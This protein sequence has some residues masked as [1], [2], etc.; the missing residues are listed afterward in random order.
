MTATFFPRRLFALLVI[1]ASAASAVLT[2]TPAM[3][4]GSH[5]PAR[6]VSVLTYN[7]HHGVGVDGVLDLERIATVIEDSGADVIGL[8]EV[9]RHWSSRSDNVDQAA[10]LAQRLHLH[11][12]FAANLDLDPVNP[13]EPRR[14]YGTAI[15][16]KYKLADVTNT[17]LPLYPGQEQRGLLEATI[18]VR[19]TRLTIANTHLTSSNDAERQEQ[20][21][22]V[23]ELLGDQR[24]PVTLIGD[25]NAEPADPEIVTLTDVFTDSWV[26]AG[27]GPGYTYEAVLPTKRIDFVLHS[28]GVRARDIEV[29]STLASDH[30][31]VLA[32]LD[33]QKH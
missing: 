16:S 11:Y 28:R 33:V 3:A 23:V 32:D 14:Q 13:G 6:P 4:G 5:G 7:I 22:K 29:L 10:W 24:N 2:T 17:L 18:K 19:G 31:P 8:Q 26:E 25:L 1:A 20:A 30:L 12:A 27:S 21:D 9:D 15:L